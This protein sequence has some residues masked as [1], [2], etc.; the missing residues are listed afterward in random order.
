MSGGP[1]LPPNPSPAYQYQSQPQADAGAIGGIGNLNTNPSGAY[2]APASTAAGSALTTTG[3]NTL[4]FVNQT[5]Q[6]GFDPQNA[7]Y[8]QQ[9]QQN[10]DQT[11]ASNA[12]AGVATTPYGAG[13]ENQSNQN[14]DINWQNQQLGRQGQAANTASTLE[15]GAGGAAS[16]G[17][18]IGQSV[19]GFANQQ[20]QQ[21]I[22]DFLAY[23]Q[24]GTGATQAGTSQYG[25]EAN[26]SLGQQGV[27]NQQLAGLGGLATSLFGGTSATGASTGL[28]GLSGL[29]A[30]FGL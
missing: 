29:T 30:L 11:R 26:A 16:T 19:P 18:A 2:N 13:L 14:F 25:A 6:T 23:L 7:L 12:A 28:G 24:G 22:A 9:F 15:S 21:A 5:L 27:N 17:T 10:Q 1:S 8:A 3:T 20:Q 4:P